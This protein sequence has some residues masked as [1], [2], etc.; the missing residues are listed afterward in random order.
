MASA[1]LLDMTAVSQLVILG[2]AAAIFSGVFG[3]SEVGGSDGIIDCGLLCSVVFFSGDVGGVIGVGGLV[4]GGGNGGWAAVLRVNGVIFPVLLAIGFDSVECLP[5]VPGCVA[6]ERVCSLSSCVMSTSSESLVSLRS[7]LVVSGVS[8]D[9]VSF[10]LG[11][12]VLVRGLPSGQIF[13][14]ASLCKICSAT[15]F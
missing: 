1:T 11:S 5:F 2:M 10:L 12:S 8:C 7:C 14:F 15:V 9:V 13:V 4:T 6:S 3:T